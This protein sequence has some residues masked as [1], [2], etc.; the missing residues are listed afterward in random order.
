[1]RRLL[2]LLLLAAGLVLVPAAF[3]APDAEAASRGPCVAGT[4]APLCHFWTGKVT[5]VADGDTIRVDIAGD[6]TSVEKT[7]RFTGI[8][9]MELQRYSKYAARRRGSCH[10]LEATALVER[11]IHRSHGVVRLAAQ[12]PNSVTGHRL[13]RSV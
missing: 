9:A 12:N 5:F 1:M 8:N 11:L 3:G 13:R 4:K 6:G 7:I 2:L 10:G